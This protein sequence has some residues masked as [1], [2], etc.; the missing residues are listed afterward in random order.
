MQLNP[1]DARIHFELGNTL[2]VV[3]GAA[4]AAAAYEK[5]SN[6]VAEGA[7]E[8]ER[9]SVRERERESETE[10]QRDRE[11]T[12]ERQRKLFRPGKRNGFSSHIDVEAEQAAASSSCG[13]GGWSS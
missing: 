1:R 12:T 8:R 11:T 10:G 2:A 5:V 13:L 7:S 6:T 4:E 3:A 9:E